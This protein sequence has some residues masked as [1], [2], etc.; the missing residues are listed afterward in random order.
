MDWSSTTGISIFLI[1]MYRLGMSDSAFRTVNS[2]VNAITPANTPFSLI[3]TYWN[4][5]LRHKLQLG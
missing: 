5:L 1:G 2:R 3:R 4:K